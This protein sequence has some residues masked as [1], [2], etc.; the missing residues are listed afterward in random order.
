MQ[1]VQV[2]IIMNS[3]TGKLWRLISEFINTDLLYQVFINNYYFFFK[4][5]NRLVPLLLGG[6]RVNLFVFI[7]AVRVGIRSVIIPKYFTT[8]AVLFIQIFYLIEH[9][10][11]QLGIINIL[12]ISLIVQRMN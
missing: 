9:W 11:H 1:Y 6:T 4:F 8:Q 5:T 10:Q 7:V 12:M 2:D 3:L